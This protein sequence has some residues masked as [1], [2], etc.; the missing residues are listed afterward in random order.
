MSRE[1]SV[2]G[3]AG[4][5]L[6]AR[7]IVS[8]AF[9]SGVLTGRASTHRYRMYPAPNDFTNSSCRLRPHLALRDF[10][11]NAPL[12]GQAPRRMP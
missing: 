9:G 6:A 4:V 7:G 11:M 3:A 1:I 5:T 2:A 10:M 8:I 12:M